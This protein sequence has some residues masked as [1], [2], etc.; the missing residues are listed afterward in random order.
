MAPQIIFDPLPTDT[1]QII[2]KM[3]PDYQE[4]KFQK[5]MFGGVSGS[6]VFVIRPVEATGEGEQLA[7]VLKIAPQEMIRKEWQAYKIYIKRWLPFNTTINQCIII[8]EVALGGLHYELTGGGVFKIKTLRDYAKQASRPKLKKTVKSLLT[9]IQQLWQANEGLEP[10]VMVCTTYDPILPVNLVL[11]PTDENSSET[12]AIIINRSNCFELD[13]S[14]IK[15]NSLIQ[16]ENFV[17]T[18]VEDKVVTFDLHPVRTNV[19]P[20]YRVR[21]KLPENSQAATYQVGQSVARVI[22]QVCQTRLGRLKAEVEQALK[23]DLEQ[24]LNLEANV[25]SLDDGNW[26]PNPLVALPDILNQRRDIKVGHIHGDMNWGNVLVTSTG[27]VRFI[28]F[29]DARRDYI[30]HDLLKLEVGVISDMVIPIIKE[31]N[32]DIKQTILRQTI[33]D[34]YQAI[35]KINWLDSL[36]QSLYEPFKVLSLIRKKAYNVLI[37]IDKT[38]YYQGLLIYLLGTMKLWSEESTHK[39]V[40]F[41]GASTILS[42]LENKPIRPTSPGGT[43]PSDSVF[44]ITRPPHDKDCWEYLKNHP[45]TITVQAPRQMGKSSMLIRMLDKIKKEQP[46]HQSVFIGF[47]GVPRTYISNTELDIKLLLQWFCR[48]IGDELGVEDE[49]DQRWT[50]MADDLKKCGDYLTKYILTQIKG[51]IVLILDNVDRV[52][53]APFKDDFFGMLRDWHEKRAYRPEFKRV[54]LLL[55]ICTEPQLLIDDSNRS[56]FNVGEKIVLPDFELEQVKQLN[57]RYYGPPLEQEQ[58][59]AL[60]ELLE[61]HPYLTHLAL[62]KLFYDALTITKLIE[63]S[64]QYWY[65]FEDHLQPYWEIIINDPSLKEAIKSVCKNEKP[66]RQARLRLEALGLLTWKDGQ[67]VFRNQLYAKYFCSGQAD[68]EKGVQ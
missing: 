31:R 41:W 48:S 10:K 43:I 20:S 1:D 51:S 36:D 56:P 60:H 61:G 37:S 29:S 19:T 21:L 52:R 68:V 53:S 62:H 14:T 55:S 44:Y 28:D 25:L 16:V 26:W 40:L 63:T 33:Y 57:Q 66:D 18:E 24:S 49:V 54:S 50:G 23:A 38:E 3:F 67:L 5:Q 30:L 65:I 12:P 59:K 15:L 7:A 4:I 22:G 34:F 2:N 17:V 8:P 39:M 9:A 46:H 35:H 64:E 32:L 27:G 11:K 6:A 13:L 58:I 47:Q 42:L 45:A